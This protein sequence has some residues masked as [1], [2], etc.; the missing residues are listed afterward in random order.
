MCACQGGGPPYKDQVDPDCTD[1]TIV[2]KMPSFPESPVNDL[3]RL[4][5]YC[6]CPIDGCSPWLNK[7]FA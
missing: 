5:G 6:G 2:S 1:M 3:G 4:W 7:L